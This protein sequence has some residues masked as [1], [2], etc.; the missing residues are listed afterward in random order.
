MGDKDK[1]DG[2][3]GNGLDMEDST[4][5]RNVAKQR[6][7]DGGEC[8]LAAGHILL[9]ELLVQIASHTNGQ[10]VDH[11]AADDLVYLVADRQDAMQQSHQQ[12][13]DQ[14]GKDA[15][16][17]VVHVQGKDEGEECRRQ[18]HPFDGN[19]YHTTA[20]AEDAGERPKRQGC[21]QAKH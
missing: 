7:L 2:S 4:P 21:G 14:A 8:P 3:Q 6:N 18:H 9:K 12:T 17:H 20:L 10:D 19:V 16:E 15:G 5:I 13:D 1:D 11:R